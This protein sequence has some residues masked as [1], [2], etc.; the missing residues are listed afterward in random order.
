M[1]N[2]RAL[3]L[4]FFVISCLVPCYAHHMAVVVNVDNPAQDISAADLAKIFK[5]QT[6][7]WP[8]GRSVVLVL[9]GSSGETLT[10]QRLNKMTAAQWRAFM[11][12]HKTS[13]V[14]A[15]SDAAVIK[16]VESNKGA[17]A[18]VEFH[19]ITSKIKVLKVGGQLPLEEGYLPH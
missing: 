8:D 14:S 18:L 19:S 15:N 4:F 7:R 17:I 13:I 10:L 9:Q 5:A 3:W 6:T 2:H 12:E 16:M 11:D 1:K